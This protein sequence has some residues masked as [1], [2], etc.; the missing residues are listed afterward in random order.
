MIQNNYAGKPTGD[1]FNYP[2]YLY[3]KSKITDI[4]KQFFINVIHK[5][6]AIYKIYYNMD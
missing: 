3:M 5:K 4:I 2:L 1:S 6:D